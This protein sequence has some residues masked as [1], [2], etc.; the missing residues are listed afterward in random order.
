MTEHAVRQALC[1]G[2]WA[3]QKGRF[4]TDSELTLLI[5]DSP[6]WLWT[7]SRIPQWILELLAFP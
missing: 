1:K 3:L 5:I 4:W 7:V 2:L 6:D